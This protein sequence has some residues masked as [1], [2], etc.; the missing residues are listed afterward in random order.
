MN[1][2][3]IQEFRANDGVV[4]GY[5][6]GMPMMLLHS[7]GA[8]SGIERTTPLVFL[9]DDSD[10]STCYIFGSKAG[11]PS[12]PDW[13][14]NVVAHPDV[15]VEIGSESFPATAVELRGESRDEVYARA[16]ARFSN[17]ADYEKMTDRVIPVIAIKRA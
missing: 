17:Y 7:T 11:A 6:E 9:P 15:T 4:G 2:Q 13:Y 10:S 5:F 3:V 8:K 14:Y 12:N 16:A 1:T